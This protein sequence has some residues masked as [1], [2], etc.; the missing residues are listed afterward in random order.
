[1][2]LQESMIMR[3][4]LVVR[5]ISCVIVMQCFIALAKTLHHNRQLAGLLGLSNAALQIQKEPAA[6]GLLLADHT[7]N[8]PTP[9]LLLFH[10]SNTTHHVSKMS[11]LIHCLGS[12]FNAMTFETVTGFHYSNSILDEIMPRFHTCMLV[13]KW[14]DLYNRLT[15]VHLG[16]S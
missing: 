2:H 5:V 3:Y 14:N 12:F 13:T 6:F 4:I 11:C 10:A 7:H 15:K 1:M 9:V 16:M 8:R